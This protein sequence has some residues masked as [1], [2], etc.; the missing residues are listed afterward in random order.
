MSHAEGH[1]FGGFIIVQYRGLSSDIGISSELTKSIP[2]SPFPPFTCHVS[3][4][5]KNDELCTLSL[6]LD[7]RSLTSVEEVTMFIEAV[8]KGK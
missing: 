2:F 7:S 5:A 6:G 3:R 8:F 4:R 1:R